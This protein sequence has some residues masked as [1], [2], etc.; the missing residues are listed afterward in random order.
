MQEPW[1]VEEA[2]KLAEVL[3]IIVEAL[4]KTSVLLQPFIPDS[5]G[6]LLDR[7]GVPPESRTWS[8]S[9]EDIGRQSSKEFLAAVQKDGKREPLFAAMRA[10]E[11]TSVAGGKPTST[12]K[13][14]TQATRKA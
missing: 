1:R 14:K 13:A 9:N 6:K 11:A 7:L 4:R 12:G 8:N 2:G 5:A 10:A 3:P